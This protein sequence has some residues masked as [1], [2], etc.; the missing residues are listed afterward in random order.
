MTEELKDTPTKEFVMGEI[1]QLIR[2]EL[3]EEIRNSNN[4]QF[5]GKL[6]YGWKLFFPVGE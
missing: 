2:D 4:E 5:F 1:E 6:K 3:L